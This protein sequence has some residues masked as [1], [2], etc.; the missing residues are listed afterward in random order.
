MSKIKVLG[1][2][3]FLVFFRDETKEVFGIAKACEKTKRTKI[4]ILGY[5]GFLVY[6]RNKTKKIFFG[7]KKVK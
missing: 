7:I 6:F 2:F 3:G 5:F 4:E 1:Y